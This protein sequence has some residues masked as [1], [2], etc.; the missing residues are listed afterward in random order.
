MKIA[1]AQINTTVGDFQGNLKLIV[2]YLR[3]AGQRNADLVVFPEMTLTGYPPKDLLERSEFIEENLHIL[4][5]LVKKVTHPACLVGFVDRCV[6]E[7]GKDLANAAAF[8]SQ[9]K[10][11]GVQRKQLLPTYDVFDEGRYFEPGKHG[12]LFSFQGKKLGISICEDI[13][14]DRSYWG[15]L[16][17]AQDP[18]QEQAKAGAELLINLSASPYSMGRGHDRQ[19]L[20]SRQAKR[21]GVP[22]VYVNLVGGN[23]D[24]VFDGS[25]MVFNA[26]GELVER[27][28]SFSEDLKII[29]TSSLKTKDGKT[30]KPSKKFVNPKEEE[31]VL[32]ALILGLKDYLNKCGFEK[33]VVGLSGGIDSALT[34]WIA[35]QALGRKNVLGVAMPSEFSSPH[36]LKDAERLAKNLKIAFRVLPIHPLYHAF[37]ETLGYLGEK[38][39]DVTLQN[40][41][42]RI[43][44][45]LL[46]ALSNREGRMLLSTGNKSEMSVGYAT[47]YGDM[48][49]GFAVL[50]DVP[51]TWVY[52]LAR[53]V[54]Q[55][56]KTIPRSSITKVPSA[57]LAPH[58]KDQDDLPPYKILDGILKAYIE[59]RKAPREIVAMGFEKKIVEDVLR[60]LD[61]NE[62]K[63]LQAP[64][65]IRITTKAFG[66]GRRVPISS[67]YRVTIK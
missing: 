5:A 48:A 17:Y 56:D 64:P 7:P 11:I 58:Q 50:K 26:R 66:Y 18:V 40:I 44:G 63:R 1:L 29:S 38:K 39:V 52:R 33:A 60:R 24:L 67:R 13:W 32:K 25:S 16:P 19:K 42:A 47:L 8:I 12:Q 20:L 3:R 30:K 2:E 10:I 51:K 62:Y 15:R 23:D 53:W 37:C 36:S 6:E 45:N 59:D 28:Q 27:L 61:G 54:H 41:Q 35:V 22:I 55:K 65:G 46:M 31:W 21:Y 14:T 57:E 43:R 34:A 4:Q 9:K 49:G